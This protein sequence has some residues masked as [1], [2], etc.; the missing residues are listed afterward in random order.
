VSE[1]PQLLNATLLLRYEDCLRAQGVPVEEWG[2]AGLS[3]DEIEATLEPLGLRA[4]IEGRAW[5]GWHDGVVGEGRGR[6]LGPQSSG[7]LSLADAVDT[8][9]EYRTIV[10]TLAEPDIPELADPDDRWH[11]SWLPIQGPQLP[12]VIDCS[13]A[14]GEP[15]PVRL[16]DLQDV[17]GSPTPKARSLG[18]VVAWRI[19]AMEAGAWRWDA[20]RRIWTVERSLMRAPIRMNPLV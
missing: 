5:W 15:T 7:F 4:P 1:P 19:E 17:A 14:E 16:V 2:R 8:Y 10:A 13:V 12:S 3:E 18:E 11:P 6:F 9:R 20:G